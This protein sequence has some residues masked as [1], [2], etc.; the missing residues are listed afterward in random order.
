M[1]GGGVV[2]ASGQ[3]DKHEPG[4]ERMAVPSSMASILEPVHT[5]MPASSGCTFW[6][7]RMPLK[8]IARLGS[9]PLPWRVQTSV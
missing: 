2:G 7:V 8:S 3:W 6:M 9:L 4:T 5:Y 1:D